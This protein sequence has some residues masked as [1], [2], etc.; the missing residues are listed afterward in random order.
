MVFEGVPVDLRVE[1]FVWAF[2]HGVLQAAWQFERGGA[3]RVWSARCVWA[4]D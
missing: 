3:G 2:G 1:F 4:R